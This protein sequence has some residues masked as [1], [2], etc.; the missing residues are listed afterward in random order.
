MEKWETEIKERHVTN[1]NEGKGEI[2]K[3]Q[4][5]KKIKVRLNSPTNI[6]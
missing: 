2:K 3:Q 4:N 6:R 5:R 1:R